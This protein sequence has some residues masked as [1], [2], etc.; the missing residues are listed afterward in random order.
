M[1]TEHFTFIFDDDTEKMAYE[2]YSKAEECYDTL[3]SFFSED[4][5]LHMP[6]YVDK[7]PRQFNAYFTNYPYNRIV[8]HD[9]PISPSLDNSKDP[10]EMTFLHELA[11]AFTF[12][13]KGSLSQSLT[14]FFG[15]WANF[16]VSLHM[17]YYMQEGIAVYAES[18]DGGGRL[19]DP[20]ALTSLLEAKIEG[21]EISYEDAAGG[22]DILPGGAMGYMYG[23][24]FSEWMADKYG[25]RDLAHYYKKIAKEFFSFPQNAYSSLF[26]TSLKKD[27][28]RFFSDLIVPENIQ[29]GECVASSSR[30]YSNLTLWNGS[31][32]ALSSSDEAIIR[33]GEDGEEEKVFSHYSPVSDLSISDDG[34]F[35]L[36]NVFDEVERMEK[37]GKHGKL[38]IREE[39]YSG[40]AFFL[41]GL[42]LFSTRDTLSYLTYI[43]GKGERTEIPLGRGVVAHEF[44]TL[45]Q[46]AAFL[47]TRGGRE[48]I[49]IVSKD[50][51]LSL[52]DTPSSMVFS[53]LSFSSGVLTF[54]WANKGGEGEMGK[55]GEL[56]ISSGRMYLSPMEFKGGVKYPVSTGDIVYF[57]SS[58]FDHSRIEKKEKAF[59]ALSPEGEVGITEY[60]A[61][62]S[63]DLSLFNSSSREYSP[64][65]TMDK[66]ALLPLSLY[67][68]SFIADELSLGL[69]WITMDAT[70]EMDFLVS[71]GYVPSLSSYTFSTRVRKG[72]LGATLSAITGKGLFA[73]EGNL[74]YSHAFPLSHSGEKIEV[75]DT[76]GWVSLGGNGQVANHFSLKYSNFRK[77]G[78]GRYDNL[79]LSLDFQM[80][81][82]SPSLT[83][84]FSLPGF[85]PRDALSP[86]DYSLPSSFSLTLSKDM[87]VMEE[88]VRLLTLEIQEG[89]RVLSLYFRDLEVYLAM[90]EYFDY[91]N[92]NAAWDARAGAKVI[93][94]P[95][96]G[97]LS[98][99]S[100]EIGLELKYNV[101]EG[102]RPSLV[103]GV[104]I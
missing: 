1:E 89:V 26:S 17:L 84:S 37:Y 13:F 81:L 7:D 104:L 8:V 19:N 88:T 10:L 96:L 12:S 86:W 30:T 34:E 27:W 51:S 45:P 100:V 79:G 14:S 102:I 66:G 36:P 93:L 72:D 52:F 70:E 15:D 92:K 87:A 74:G 82:L 59:F 103:M 99:N 21:K 101:N 62:E 58:R 65:S 61:E 53:S 69:S 42:L 18:R 43:N 23:G 67:T 83:F 22:R 28:D 6:V 90:R 63:P 11:H 38:E 3:V 71:G 16:P 20:F 56:E 50:L 44:V 73:Y 94:S 46:G 49:A 85:I 64:F 40:G 24:A 55:Y 39:G 95:I 9:A 60:Q 32:Y 35:L 91:Q 97:N 68:G 76:L 29:E 48:Q 4:P 98:R 78:I 33:I 31:L 41:D 57:V 5:N 54:S 80:L 2:L 75:K 47:I 25:E 77:K